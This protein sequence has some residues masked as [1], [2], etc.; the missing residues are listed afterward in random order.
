MQCKCRSEQSACHLGAMNNQHNLMFSRKFCTRLDL[1][2]MEWPRKRRKVACTYT[3]LW[4]AV[5]AFSASR[6]PRAVDC[7][8]MLSLGDILD[9][10][11]TCTAGLG[12]FIC[13]GSTFSVSLHCFQAL[14]AFF[15]SRPSNHACQGHQAVLNAHHCFHPACFVCVCGTYGIPCYAGLRQ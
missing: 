5:Q 10:S 8:R 12:Q 7:F 14:S 4:H 9:P 13:A 1:K 2:A 3:L 6:A 11:G 15:Q